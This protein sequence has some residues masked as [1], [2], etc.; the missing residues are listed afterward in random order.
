MRHR[1]IRNPRFDKNGG[2]SATAN[3][4]SGVLAPA[5][6]CHWCLSPCPALVRQSFLR[7]SRWW[8]DG[9]YP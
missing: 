5:R 9:R 7:H 2:L 8:R 1:A 3:T 4:S 6:R